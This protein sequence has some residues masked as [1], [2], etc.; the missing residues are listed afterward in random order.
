MNLCIV[1]NGLDV[2]HKYKTRY[3]DFKL[4]MEH[5]L[6]SSIVPD[7][8]PDLPDVVIGNHG[9][10]FVDEDAAVKVLMWLFTHNNVLDDKWSNF[11]E[12][13]Y[14]IDMEGVL[15]ENSWFVDDNS[16]DREGDINPFKQGAYYREIADSIRVC[17]QY[18]HVLFQRWIEGVD[19]KKTPLLPS[20]K[21]LAVESLFLS[22]NYTE[23]LEKLY[24]VPADNVCYIHG[25]RN[26]AYNMTKRSYLSTTKRLIIGHGND[27]PKDYGGANVEA[28]E[29]FDEVIKDLRKHTDCIIKNHSNF[30]HTIQ[31]SNIDKIYS[32]G[33][34]YGNVDLPYIVHICKL[35]QND[36][37]VW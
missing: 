4:W 3:S 36:D 37:I 6:G 31:K 10:K 24:N 15:E 34:S 16:R 17:I 35:L 13:L 28:A 11:E 32:F 12:S 1:G 23:T 7:N 25:I 33:F 19:I 22:F 26:N 30:W 2:A 29:V 20:V 27:L 18:T 8:V 9:E 5:Q 14:N 21:R